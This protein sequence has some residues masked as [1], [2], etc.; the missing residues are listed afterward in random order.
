M[1]IKDLI[2]IMKDAQAADGALMLAGAI[3][4]RYSARLEI[5]FPLPLAQEA[6][7]ARAYRSTSARTFVTAMTAV[8]ERIDIVR[9][10]FEDWAATLG[11]SH[12]WRTVE[13]DL[14][15]ALS[16]AARCADL[17]VVSPSVDVE[18]IGLDPLDILLASGC[19]TLVVPRGGH[20]ARI[21][22]S[23]LVAWNASRAARR[24][25]Q[26]ALPLL[27]EMR[28]V[29]VLCL[30]ASADTIGAHLA[31]H[32]ITARIE[33]HPVPPA[34]IAAAILARAAELKSDLI[35]MGAEDNAD[36]ACATQRDLIGGLS[37][38]ALLS[39]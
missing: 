30:G 28:T 20:S 23:A 15:E 11:I 5:T 32:G 21:W 12:G 36:A 8:R 25:V 35:V 38:P 33:H 10:A 6:A 24:A 13:T 17:A 4:V 31:R 9:H 27:K 18:E 39:R 37:M 19:P 1:P 29:T 34:G 26:D 14:P 22:G 3:A 16:Q 2:V 7:S